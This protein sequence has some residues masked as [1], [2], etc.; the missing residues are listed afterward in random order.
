MARAFHLR[1]SR[2]FLIFVISLFAIISGDIAFAQSSLKIYGQVTDE[3]G[4]VANATVKIEKSKY[5]SVTDQNGYYYI[6]DI[7]PGHYRLSCSYSSFNWTSI[8][9]SLNSGPAIRQDIYL[10]QNVFVIEPVY[11][12]AEKPASLA[13][14]TM[15]VKIYELDHSGGETAEDV[16]RQIPGINLV[17]SSATGELF[18]STGGIRPQG[19]NVLIDGRKLNSLLTGRADLNQLPLSAI[20]KIEYYSP[21]SASN[22]ADGGLGGTLNFVTTKNIRPELIDLHASRG[23]F[24]DE[25]Y[26]VSLGKDFGTRGIATGSWE[27]GYIRNNY[28]C[29]DN[30]DRPLT[31]RNAFAE[32]DKYFLSYTNQLLGNRFEFSG[33]YY[34]GI[35]GVP[36]PVNS[37]SEEAR[38]NKQS[39]SMGMDVSRIIN[40][41]LKVSINT[42]FQ[43][44][45]ARYK[46][47]SSWIPYKTKYYEREI[48]TSL[49]IELS[50]PAGVFINHSHS[51]TGSLLNGAD[52]IRE[53]NSLGKRHRDVYRIHNGLN[54]VWTINR[55]AIKTGGAYT[56]NRVAHDNYSSGS[57]AASLTYN[58]FAKFGVASTISHTFRLPGLVEL[59]WHDNVF[60]LAPD[61][62]L[63]PEQSN[64]VTSE[65]FSE[66]RMLGDWRLSLEYQDIRYKDLI[67]W[68]RSVGIKYKAANVSK[69]DY[70]GATV[71]I[72]YKSPQDYIT[73]DFSRTK[74][75]SINRE[76]QYY[77]LFITFQPPYTNKLSL[78]LQ[79]KNPYLKAEMVDIG[80]RYTL[81]ANS[82]QLDP[83]TL[84]NLSCGFDL[85][86][87]RLRTSW[88]FEI[89]NLTDAEYEYL[90]NQPMPPRNY[91]V[92]FNFKF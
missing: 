89:N 80:K 69:S 61:S 34:A 75:S 9:C 44:R 76:E 43:E 64:A 37:P 92:T 47:Y 35:N 4:P 48:E 77:G 81:E 63:K 73:L 85:K 54:T 78:R 26:A 7:P 3:N 16:I 8:D 19:V 6:Y 17:K 82:K 38:S 56:F 66:F 11:V 60:V 52:F 5:S 39:S 21:G 23:S 53:N 65:L 55:I 41:R 15:N 49:G 12:E 33:F 45:T 2:S 18:V 59:Y 22:T 14:A 50:L 84:V 88:T 30:L 62:T 51:Y 71:A 86:Y 32:Y 28:D 67:Y 27:K 87:K 91:N 79:Y 68:R 58:W 42:S 57:V 36:G 74:S 83:Y 40:K 24:T 13:P 46:D 20:S 25:D 72:A 1:N 10:G 29:I 90:D 31:R 70:F